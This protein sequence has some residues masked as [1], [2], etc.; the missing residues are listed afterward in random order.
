[1]KATR[2]AAGL[3]K[4][5]KAEGQADAITLRPSDA[6]NWIIVDILGEAAQGCIMVHPVV[7]YGLPGQGG[8]FAPASDE[9]AALSYILTYYMQTHGGLDAQ[10]L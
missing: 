3:D 8:R 9:Q 4:I 7:M 2:I 6:D 10:A 5:I 1:M